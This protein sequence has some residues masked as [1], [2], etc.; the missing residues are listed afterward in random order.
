MT[1]Q[2]SKRILP[3]PWAAHRSPRVTWAGRPMPIVV[4]GRR[5]TF[6][7]AAAR[8]SHYRRL[9]VWITGCLRG[10]VV[11][12]SAHLFRADGKAPTRTLDAQ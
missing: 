6:Q 11:S 4:P 2:P 1:L 12:I 8:L 7:G 5:E 3:S 9:L 10:A